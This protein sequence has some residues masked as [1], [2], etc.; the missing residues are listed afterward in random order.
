[1]SP[2]NQESKDNLFVGITTDQTVQCFLDEGD[3]IQA[4]HDRLFSAAKQFLERAVEYAISH[5]PFSDP[6]LESNTPN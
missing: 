2:D 1:M 5:L 3:I 6:V 4:E